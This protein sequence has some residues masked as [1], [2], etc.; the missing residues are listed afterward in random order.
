M[1]SVYLRSSSIGAVAHDICTQGGAVDVAAV[2]ERSVY[3]QL[4]GGFVCVGMAEIGDG[5][6]NV[7]LSV[8][9]AATMPALGFVRDAEGH[10]EGGRISFDEGPTLDLAGARVW[11]VPPVPSWSRTGLEQGAGLLRETVT[12]LL[13]DDGLA[14]LVFAPKAPQC[15]TP[16]A[17]AAKATLGELRSELPDAM[18]TQSV[19]RIARPATLLLGLGPGLTPSGDDLLGGVL[20]AL[21]ALGHVALRNGLWEAL[22]PELGD[23]TNEISAM[24]LALA[25]DGACSAILH[26]AL[27]AAMAGD[28]VTGSQAIGSAVAIGHT[29][30]ADTLAGIALTLEAWLAADALRRQQTAD[31]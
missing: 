30:G 13:P 8:A 23:L 5:P 15:R 24:H 1:T 2:F 17:E 11:Q 26:R 3:L 10:C 29:S 22:L 4:P 31:P 28:A 14:A 7:L 25:A 6:I 27:A 9:G 19:A 20:L 21:S 12:P 16:T 18:M